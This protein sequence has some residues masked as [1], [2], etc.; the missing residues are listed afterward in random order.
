[1]SSKIYK[2]LAKHEEGEV[3]E[4]DEDEEKQNNFRKMS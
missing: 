3:E 1:M 4:E 2:I